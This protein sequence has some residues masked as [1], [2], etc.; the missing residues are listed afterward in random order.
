MRLRATHRQA[1]SSRYLQSGGCWDVPSLDRLAAD[2]PV[3]DGTAVA[4][5]STR[6]R[7]RSAVHRRR[8]VGRRVCAPPG[9]RRG[10][11]WP[12][13]FPTAPRR[14]SCSGPAGGWA[15]SPFPSTIWWAR[16]KWPGCS[17]RST[18]SL[19]LAGSG[20]AL[21]DRPWHAPR[22]TGNGQLGGADRRSAPVRPEPGT[23]FG[24]RRGPVHL[25]V[26]RRAQ[27]GAPHPP[28]P[29]LQGDRSWPQHTGC[30][31]PTSC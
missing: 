11:R 18:P 29:V 31:L 21:H 15:P 24:P 16:R 27:G 12:G 30:A 26:D 25:R 9:W 3:V 19:V 4:D 1:A 5:S 6:L 8:L 17:K 2:H 7:R 14:C 20:L 22:P 28:G 23:R 13:S 10:T